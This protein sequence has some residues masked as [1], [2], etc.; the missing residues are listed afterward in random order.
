MT[1]DQK[2]IPENNQTKNNPKPPTQ[3]SIASSSH[4]LWQQLL[5]GPF[6]RNCEL[7]LPPQTPELSFIKT[8]Q[9]FW[10]EGLGFTSAP[11]HLAAPGFLNHHCANGGLCPA[12]H[13]HHCPLSSWEEGRQQIQQVTNLPSQAPS[14]CVQ[15][16]CD[17][18]K[19]RSCHLKHDTEVQNLDWD[20]GRPEMPWGE[21]LA[22]AKSDWPVGTTAPK[23]GLGAERSR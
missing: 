11:W 4:R 20:L 13:Q 22:A 10:V 12:E 5:F 2:Y 8:A 23:L 17:L 21:A 9:G 18:H 7:F 19:S 6:S 1:E 16:N 3:A 15:I 14:W